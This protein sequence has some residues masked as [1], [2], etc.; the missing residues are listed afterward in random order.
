MTTRGWFIDGEDERS[1]QSI[2]HLLYYPITFY[3]RWIDLS[4]R[5]SSQLDSSLPLS[6]PSPPLLARTLARFPEIRRADN[7]KGACRHTRERALR[8]SLARSLARE[9]DTVM[10]Q[11]EWTFAT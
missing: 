7:A 10:R 9:R 3:A 1:A 2:S 8:P 5:L 4:R 6:P 11:P